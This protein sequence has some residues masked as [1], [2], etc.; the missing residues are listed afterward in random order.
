MKIGEKILKIN[1]DIYHSKVA[2]NE[3]ISMQE[4]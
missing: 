3:H 4:N 1:I 2:I